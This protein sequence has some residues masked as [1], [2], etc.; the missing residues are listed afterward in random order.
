MKRISWLLIVPLV[1]VAVSA[2]VACVEFQTFTLDPGGGGAGGMGGES[3]TSITTSSSTSS[4]MGGM[5]G[6]GGGPECASSADCISE[7]CRTAMGCDAQ[8]K[9]VWANTGANLKT[10]SQVYGDCKDRVC[11]GNGGVTSV[12][13]TD[14]DPYVYANPCY[15]QTCNILMPMANNGVKCTTP[16]G[17]SMGTCNNL[18]CIDCMAD[19]DCGVNKCVNKRCVPET[20]TDGLLTMGIETDIDCGGLSCA[21]CAEGKICAVNSDCEG[22]CDSGTLLCLAASCADGVLNGSETDIDCGGSCAS[23]VP[24]K[25]CAASVNMQKNCLVP[26]D[27]ESGVCKVG[28]CQE[29]TCSDYVKNQ[30][31][32]GVDCGGPIAMCPPCPKKMP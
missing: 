5:G 25:K 21:P 24:P 4:G 13:N 14:Q 11:D 8:R 32:D 16:W 29:P 7:E 2:P 12:P 27:C 9:C 22:S 26:I 1:L 19:G 30:D 18:Q 20:C 10:Q 28:E 15:A 3:S 23:E 31:E 6:M 17:N